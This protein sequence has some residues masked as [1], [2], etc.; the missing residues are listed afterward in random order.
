MEQRGEPIA[1]AGNEHDSLRLVGDHETVGDREAS[2][3][4]REFGVLRTGRH[5]TTG[6]EHHS[7]RHHE[8]GEG[9]PVTD[10]ASRVHRLDLL[11]NL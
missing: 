10:D 3:G 5:G 4:S 7:D 8:P 9:R 11:T 2:G 1:S 6:A